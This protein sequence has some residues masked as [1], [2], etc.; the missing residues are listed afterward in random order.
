MTAFF[1][2]GLGIALPQTVL[3]SDE[4]D[5]AA[6]RPRG[7]LAGRTGVASRPVCTD[8][9]QEG[10]GA[11]AAQ[12][13]L[14]QAGLAPD[15]IDLLLFCGAVGR[16]PIPATAPLIARTL[17][18]ADGQVA[19]F[20]VNATCLGFLVGLD[21][22]SLMLAAGRARRALVVAAEIASR[23]LPWQSEPET[24]ALFGD[25]AAAA[26]LEAGAGPASGTIR[27]VQFETWP[28]GYDL[29]E[30]ASGGTRFSLSKEPQ[31]FAAGS[32]FKMDAKALFRLS[33]EH[34]P[35]FVDRLLAKAGWRREEVDLVI[36]HQASRLALQ[37]LVRRCGF[38]AE[39]VVDIV[40]RSG[41][42]V[43]ASI[44]IAWHHAREQGLIR[45]GARLLMLGTSA[46]VSFGGMAIEA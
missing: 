15:A 37:H 24:A 8:E 35:A 26:I 4:V 44:P 27:A 46:G 5:A 40:D 30:L 31:A 41:N 12:R 23:A 16:Q 17:G 43:S 6:G 32:Q 7:W 19:A 21:V 9:T 13:A 29:C 42:Q 10:L 38:A 2:R 1:L 34:Y 25:G 11:E 3:H 28:S 22:A 39:R 45:Q 14:E 33:A 20:D 18:M 36:P